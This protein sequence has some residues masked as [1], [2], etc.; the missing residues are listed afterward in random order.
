VGQKIMWEG[1]SL[2]EPVVKAVLPSGLD[3]R[4]EAQQQ[5]ASLGSLYRQQ[6]R[7]WSDSTSTGDFKQNTL[8]IGK[9][10]GETLAGVTDEDRFRS[11]NVSTRFAGSTRLTQKQISDQADTSVKSAFA[12]G[13]DRTNYAATLES[14]GRA[15]AVGGETTR[16]GSGSAITATN[17]GNFKQDQ[18]EFALTIAEALANGKLFDRMDE[19]MKGMAGM[20]DM[21]GGRMGDLDPQKLASAFAEA[22]KAAAGDPRLQEAVPG[23]FGK[24]DQ[25]M[26]TMVRDPML[27]AG[28]AKSDAGKGRGGA[29]MLYNIQKTLEGGDVLAKFDMMGGEFKTRTGLTANKSTM[30]ELDKITGLKGEERQKAI[31][32]SAIFGAKGVGE[33]G[34]ERAQV[35]LM[36]MKDRYGLSSLNETR[37]ALSLSDLKVSGS[38]LTDEQKTAI[39][40]LK[41][42]S[43]QVQTAVIMGTESA[44]D[45]QKLMQKE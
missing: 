29:D 7:T 43:N 34:V 33:A 3:Y 1:K 15:G 36:S 22:N 35:A 44:E 39:Q 11:L 26:S 8:G 40:G 13:L 14:F 16:T 5:G 25:Q 4:Q 9:Y 41:S 12:L 30:D 18:K 10:D 2:L 21:V 28:Y 38:K 42:T 20:A 45:I 37:G 17:S 24:V 19:V 23:L 31:A 27:V 6:Q 32:A